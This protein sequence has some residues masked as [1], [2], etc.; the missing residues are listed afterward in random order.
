MRSGRQCSLVTLGPTE[1]K[2][3]QVGVQVTELTDALI[4]RVEERGARSGLGYTKEKLRV[5]GGSP[6]SLGQSSS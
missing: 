2:Y 4:I 1:R 5:R 3:R 6:L